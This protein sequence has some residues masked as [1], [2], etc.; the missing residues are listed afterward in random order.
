MDFI[1]SIKVCYSKY[2]DF[3]GTASRSE[4]WW[5]YLYTWILALLCWIPFVN[6][7]IIIIIIGTV[8]P[9]VAVAIRRL[10]DLNYSGWRILWGMI[11]LFGTILLIIWYAREGDL[12]NTARTSQARN[13]TSAD[14]PSVTFEDP[15]Q[16]E[17]PHR[18]MDDDTDLSSGKTKFR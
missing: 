13:D 2:T 17:R 15:I 6:I 4:F 10:H 7:L 11:P 1:T 5:F 12:N 3:E 18:R 9:Y 14:N 8:I 16:T